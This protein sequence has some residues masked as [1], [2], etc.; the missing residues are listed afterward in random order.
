ME[1]ILE[2][3]EPEER[4]DVIGDVIIGHACAHCFMAY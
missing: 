3:F 1:Q 2:E 4:Y